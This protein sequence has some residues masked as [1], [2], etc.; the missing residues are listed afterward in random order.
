MELTL[1]R[2]LYRKDAVEAAI[3]AFREVAAVTL[4]KGGKGVFTLRFEGVDP[5]VGEGVVDEFANYAL[6]LTVEGRGE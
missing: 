5:E 1:S 2:K 6:G 3:E 4:E